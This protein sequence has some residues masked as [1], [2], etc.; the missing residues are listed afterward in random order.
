MLDQIANVTKLDKIIICGD[1]NLPNIIW[2]SQPLEFSITDYVS[3]TIK[4]NCLQLLSTCAYHGLQQQFPKH[5]TKNYSLDLLF[6]SW[7]FVQYLDCQDELVTSDQ[8]HIAVFFRWICRIII[9]VI[10]P[11]I[12][13]L[14]S[15]KLIMSNLRAP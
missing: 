6:S 2:K 14:I 10:E 1:F 9:Y 11:L 7:S 15:L 4:Q 13:G 5:P 12:I 3:P 8:H